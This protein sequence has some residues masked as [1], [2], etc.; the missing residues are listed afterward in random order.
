MFDDRQEKLLILALD[1]GCAPGEFNNA[2][3]AFFRSLK[4]QYKSG[5]ELLATL[6]SSAATVRTIPNGGA[7]YGTVVLPFGK[8]RGRQLRNVP[9]DYL[10]WM[11]RECDSLTWPMRKAIERYLREA[12]FR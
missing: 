9:V 12:D 7:N 1:P 8:Y 2:A 3:T 11:I 4:G 10:L 5:H 6:K